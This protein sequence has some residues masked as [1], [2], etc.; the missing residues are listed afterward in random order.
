MKQSFIFFLSLSSLPFPS[1]LL[2]LSEF[3]KER[4]GDFVSEGELLGPHVIDIF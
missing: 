1:L 4:R 2:T 3:G